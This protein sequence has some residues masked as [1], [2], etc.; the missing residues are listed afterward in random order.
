[1]FL[2]L[3]AGALTSLKHPLPETVVGDVQGMVF[4][5][6]FYNPSDGFPTFACPELSLEL[7]GVSPARA[8]GMVSWAIRPSLAGDRR[9]G[10][11]A[12]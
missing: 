6:T 12:R 4:K 3:L 8:Q 10:G 9:T 2:A 5:R 7:M 11:P 1:M